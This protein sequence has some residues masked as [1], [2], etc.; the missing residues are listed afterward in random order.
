MFS[1][2][3]LWKKATWERIGK[4]LKCLANGG[5]LMAVF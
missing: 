4:Y 2:A 5:V 1:F 3:F